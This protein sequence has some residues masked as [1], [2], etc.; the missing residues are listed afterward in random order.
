MKKII[1]VKLIIFLFITAVTYSCQNQA[2]ESTANPASGTTFPAA[3]TIYPTPDII[4]P[5]TEIIYP[6]PRAY[7]F[8]RE[9]FVHLAWFYKPPNPNQVNSL[10]QNFDFFILTHKDEETRDQLRSM[11]VSSPIFQYLLLTEIRQP[12]TCDSDNYG[13]QVAY[14]KGDFC[15]IRDQRPEWFLL[16][17]SGN[18]IRNDN[19]TY[20]MDPGNPEFRKFWLQRAREMQAQYGWDGLFIDNVEASLAKFRQMGVTPAK[21]PSDSIYQSAVNEFLIYLRENN[22][23]LNER[24]VLANIVSVGDDDVWMRYIENLDGAMIES[25]AVDWSN[26]YK[27][28]I[29]WEQQMDK[30]EKALAQ[31]KILVLVSQGREYGDFN[32]EQFALASYLLVSNGNTAFRYVN[33]ENYR[34]M[35]LYE[36]LFIDP[37]LPF[38][39][40]YRE[41]MA[42]RR[43][44]TNGYVL[45]NPWTNSSQIEFIP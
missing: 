44:F 18:P 22:P 16:D 40:R 31:G 34:D 41:G 10:A 20:F 23:Y 43:D 2:V 19:N 4:S 12:D 35:W 7:P 36:N 1:K 17:E 29:E 3:S 38:G 24:L 26:G 45:V 14:Q 9:K 6:T 33:S 21:Y 27:S 37:G 28:A 11:G 32:R 8:N 15:L 25:F 42:W 30:I 5:P 39:P 13:N